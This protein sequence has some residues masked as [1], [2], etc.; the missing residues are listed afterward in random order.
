MDAAVTQALG[1]RVEQRLQ[2]AAQVSQP[3]AA[4]LTGADDNLPRRLLKEAAKTGPAKGKVAELDKMLPEY[5]ELRGWTPDGSVT[6]QIRE[7][8]GLPGQG[9]A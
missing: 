8:L 5:Y 2:S 6:P 1:H 3:L 9:G 7:R 4:G